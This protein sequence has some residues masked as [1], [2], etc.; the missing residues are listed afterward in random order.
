MFVLQAAV[1]FVYAY[2]IFQ[3]HR[4]A[5]GVIA[6]P[7]EVLDMAQTVA[8]ESKLVSIHTKP[9]VTDVERLLAVI[10]W[11][12]IFEA[13]AHNDTEVEVRGWYLHKE[14]SFQR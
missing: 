4:I 12:R 2:D 14:P 6:V 5:L 7:I 10:G 1:L 11:P 8:S 3:G 13:L 9:G